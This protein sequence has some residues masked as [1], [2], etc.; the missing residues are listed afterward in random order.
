LPQISVVVPIF[1]TERFIS[2][3]LES[4][5]VQSFSD[6]EIVCIDDCSSDNSGHIV[7]GFIKNDSR[8]RLINHST[9]LGPGGARNSGIAA[10][11][12]EYVAFVDSDDYVDPNFLEYLYEATDFGRI[13]I[14]SCGYRV[15]DETG[16]TQWEHSP[17]EETFGSLLENSAFW[18]A[19]HPHFC[20]KLWRK[21]L[22]VDNKIM[23]PEQSY[24]EDVYTIPEILFHAKSFHCGGKVLYHY[25]NRSGS[26][27]NSSGKKHLIDLLLAIDNIK[28]LLVKKGVYERE[29][30]SFQ[31]F[32]EGLFKF[33]ARKLATMRMKNDPDTEKFIRLSS[34]LCDGYTEYDNRVRW[35]KVV[36]KYPWFHR[37]FSNLSGVRSNQI[38]SVPRSMKSSI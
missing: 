34:V 28:D 20:D 25:F 8:V 30:E 37:L 22:I 1:N 27:T 3:C 10:A 12:G 36:R 31:N 24:W 18:T 38:S 4:I 33:H 26:I 17:E 15:L 5:L 6:I 2:R 21:S 14:A 16:I 13:D 19:T 23:C 7:R 35:P 29:A 11:T 9:N 32:Y